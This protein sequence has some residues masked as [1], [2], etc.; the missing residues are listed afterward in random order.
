MAHRKETG[1][2]LSKHGFVFDEYLQWQ[3][4][5]AAGYVLRIYT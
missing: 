4:W 1:V 5:R 2:L 3:H